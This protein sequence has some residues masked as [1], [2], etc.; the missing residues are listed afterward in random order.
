MHL[1]WFTTGGVLAVVCVF[2]Y[3]LIR[4]VA[5]RLTTSTPVFSS[6]LASFCILI[7]ARTGSMAHNFELSLVAR[8]VL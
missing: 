4:C 8:P 2:T 7:V 6:V 5:V 1:T 3:W